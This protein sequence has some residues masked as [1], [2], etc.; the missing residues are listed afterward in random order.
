MLAVCLEVLILAERKPENC[1]G[2][3]YEKDT[4]HVTKRTTKENDGLEQGR[5]DAKWRIRQNQMRGGLEKVDKKPRAFTSL[6]HE[7]GKAQAEGAEEGHE[8]SRREEKRI[9]ALK[10]SVM[11]V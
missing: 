6:N 11:S 10:Q 1:D 9:V 8:Q 7:S 2:A 3:D 4:D 5:R